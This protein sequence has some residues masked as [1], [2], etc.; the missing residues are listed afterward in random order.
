MCKKNP[1]NKYF[2]K[3][4]HM[5]PIYFSS[6]S[7]RCWVVHLSHRCLFARYL[8]VWSPLWVLRKNRK[9]HICEKQSN[10]KIDGFAWSCLVLNEMMSDLLLQFIIWTPTSKSVF[11]IG[12]N[13]SNSLLKNNN[14]KHFTISFFANIEVQNMFRAE[15][16]HLKGGDVSVA[17][18][19][20]KN[21]IQRQGSTH[22]M[23]P[24]L[25]G[26]YKFTIMLL[27]PWVSSVLFTTETLSSLWHQKGERPVCWL[28]LACLGGDLLDWHKADWMKKKINK[29]N[30]NI[31]KWNVY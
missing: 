4:A 14:Y 17:G 16:I 10:G 25:L 1:K 22:H 8:P 20:W 31:S 30:K 28:Y 7:P 19:C 9:H 3:A 23:H 6:E 12:C 29:I 21:L 18:H 13:H 5:H 24:T 15:M 11:L 26:K 27:F 2:F